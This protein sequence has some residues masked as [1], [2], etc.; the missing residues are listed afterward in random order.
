MKNAKLALL[1]S[2][3]VLASAC[4]AATPAVTEPHETGPGAPAVPVNAVTAA[5]SGHEGA[6]AVAGTW[7]GAPDQPET[8]YTGSIQQWFGDDG[9]FYAVYEQPATE[10]DPGM[11]GWG[12]IWADPDTGEA[13][14]WWTDTMAPGMALEMT[15]T[16]DEDGTITLDGTGPGPDEQPMHYRSV[17]RFPEDGPDTFEMGAVLP[18]GTFMVMMKYTATRTGDAAKTW[19]P[20]APAAEPP[21]VEPPVEESPAPTEPPATTTP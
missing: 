10:T 7:Q 16:A 17:Y 12:K 1:V 6:F 4:G 5:L 18:D 14:M 13:R 3:A 9:L 8:P 21:V 20:P 11:K 19:E 15:G 2:L